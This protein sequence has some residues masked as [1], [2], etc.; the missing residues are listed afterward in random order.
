MIPSGLYLIW[1]LKFIIDVTS[2]LSGTA[3][4]RPLQSCE[5][6]TDVCLSFDHPF[7]GLAYC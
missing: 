2:V 3:E 7:S 6:F 5:A 4:G 1:V